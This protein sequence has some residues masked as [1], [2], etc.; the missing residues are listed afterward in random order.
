MLMNNRPRTALVLAGGGSLG[1]IQVGM[2][3]EL[4]AAGEAFD[5]V[6]GASAGAI[7]GAY[8]AS[9]PTRDGVATLEHLWR[10]I[11]RSDILPI[12]L[13][14]LLNLLLRRDYIDDG[15]ALRQLLH[16][17]LGD[18]LIEGTSLPL[19]IVATDQLSGDEIVLS[20]GPMVPAV[21]AS[22]AIPGIFPSVMI[23]ERALI[24]GGVAN[25]AP[26]SAAIARGAERIVVLPTGFACAPKSIPR[27]AAAK[28]MHAVNLLVSRQLVHDIGHFADRAAI[29]VVPTLCPL[30]ASS[31][32]YSAAASLIDRAVVSTRAW[33]A[34]GGLQKTGAP[35]ALHDHFH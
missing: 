28:V 7:N 8:F 19:H 20:D 9:N 3:R 12:S 32:D 11:R 34:S 23:G 24:D 25:N 31:Y 30:E 33:I 26:I 22:A 17:H 14:T 10:G 6:V 15:S 13:G 29:C 16:H 4:L 2:L 18:S 5:F 27:G 35:S 1:A 21:L